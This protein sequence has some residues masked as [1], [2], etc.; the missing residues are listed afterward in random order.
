M[1][2]AEF[3]DITGMPLNTTDSRNF[4][5]R[6]EVNFKM[7]KVGLKNVVGVIPGR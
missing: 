2:G 5:V 6:V 4:T 7:E 3:Y 1:S